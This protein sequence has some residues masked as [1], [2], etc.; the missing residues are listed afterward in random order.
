MGRC[1][2][3]PGCAYSAWSCGLRGIVAVALN[4]RPLKAA[5]KLPAVFPKSRSCDTISQW[6]GEQFFLRALVIDFTITMVAGG[7]AKLLGTLSTAVTGA[8]KKI[9]LSRLRK[10]E[11]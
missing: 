3:V 6:G 10:K 2:P 7:S 1:G 11:I 4:S 5:K 9:Y 8:L